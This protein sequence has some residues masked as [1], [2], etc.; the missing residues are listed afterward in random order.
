MTDIV[1]RLRADGETVETLKAKG[2]WGSVTMLEQD[3]EIARLREDV[4]R[5]TG[6]RDRQYDY[7]AESIFK[8]AALEAENERL[9]AALEE[10][11]MKTRC[12]KAVEIAR[13]ALNL[14]QEPRERLSDFS[15]SDFEE[16]KE[17]KP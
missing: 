15:V 3:A 8:Y 10:I 7:N 14:S 9:R 17:Q 4:E 5:L 11:N 6:E 12:I 13:A 2:H 16:Q 1:Q